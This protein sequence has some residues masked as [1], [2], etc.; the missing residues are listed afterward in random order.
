MLLVGVIQHW[1]VQK[2]WPSRTT[3]QWRSSSS[4]PTPSHWRRSRLTTADSGTLCRVLHHSPPVAYAQ[5]LRIYILPFKGRVHPQ[6]VAL[7]RGKPCRN[8][9]FTSVFFL[10]VFLHRFQGL[11]CFKVRAVSLIKL[12]KDFFKVSFHICAL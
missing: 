6:C 9:S 12:S 1:S 3:R 4:A 7:A 11:E 10:F 2:E 8:C 5:A